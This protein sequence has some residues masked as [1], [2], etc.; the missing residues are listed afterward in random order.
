MEN[1]NDLNI[2]TLSAGF[3]ERMQCPKIVFDGDHE[4]NELQ[5]CHC[6]VN[7]ARGCVLFRIVC[8]VGMAFQLLWPVRKVVTIMSSVE[9]VENEV[10]SQD[11]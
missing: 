9:I 3:R 11:S 2:M 10:S 1:I 5:T 8:K 7:V 6:H 4:N